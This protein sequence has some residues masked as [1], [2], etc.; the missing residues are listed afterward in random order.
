MNDFVV[1]ALNYESAICDQ[2]DNYGIEQTIFTDAALSDM[3]SKEKILVERGEREY[4]RCKTVHIIAYEKVTQVLRKFM[5]TEKIKMLHHEYT[6]QSNEV[7]SKSVRAYAPENK[8]YSL[9]KS[10]EARLSIAAG[11][12]IDGYHLLWKQLYSCFPCI[13]I[14]VSKSV[15]KNWT[16]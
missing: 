10:L 3:K 11:S 5:T 16:L 13:F 14:P 1:Q 2:L 15:Y 6:T 12:Q 9:T 7:L 4:Y 8:T